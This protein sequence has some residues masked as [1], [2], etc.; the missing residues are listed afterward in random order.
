LAP[1]RDKVVIEFRVE[2]SLKR[3]LFDLGLP[4]LKSFALMNGVKASRAKLVEGSRGFHGIQ[5]S[6]L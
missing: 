5:R 1:D 2:P 3:L 4:M 6:V